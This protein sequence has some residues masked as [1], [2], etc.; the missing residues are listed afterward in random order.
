MTGEEMVHTVLLKIAKFPTSD[1]GLLQYSIIIVVVRIARS[2]P[3]P[4]NIA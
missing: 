2:Q 1:A 3:Q 4:Q